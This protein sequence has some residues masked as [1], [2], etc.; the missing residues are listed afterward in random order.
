MH[1]VLVCFQAL[2]H[3]CHF[4]LCAMQVNQYASENGIRYCLIFT[5]Q[6]SWALEAD[7]SNNLSISPAFR[8]DATGPSVKHASLQ[9]TEHAM[10][11]LAL[12]IDCLTVWQ[13]CN[14][15]VCTSNATLRITLL[16]L[17]G[18][19]VDF[20][21]HQALKESGLWPTWDTLLVHPPSETAPDPSGGPSTGPQQPPS[22]S[23]RDPSRRPPTGKRSHGS[24]QPPHGAVALG[25]A[26]G[27]D[28]PGTLQSVLS[29]YAFGHAVR[30][31]KEAIRLA[32]EAAAL[33]ENMIKGVLGRGALGAVFEAR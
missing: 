17:C 15:H 24:S 33:E 26:E 19:V 31:S 8:Y 28:P 2:L 5:H 10:T 7:G 18:Q 1:V 11:C 32:E 21:S 22:R 20:I 9:F 30:D 4:Q 25:P 13:L 3:T 29:P 14:P 12:L 27:A 6:W 23:A 16:S